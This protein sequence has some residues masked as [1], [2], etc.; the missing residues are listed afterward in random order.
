MGQSDGKIQGRTKQYHYGL[1]RPR[2]KAYDRVPRE[3]LWRS[4]RLRGVSEYLVDC[5]RDMYTINVVHMW[6][7]VLQG[8]RR[9]SKSKL[10]YIREVHLALSC[11]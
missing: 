3:E 7:F 6:F 10:G 1:H 8:K 11:L 5:I 9:V 2:K 4:L